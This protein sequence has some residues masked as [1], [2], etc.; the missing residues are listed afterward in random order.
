MLVV[1]NGTIFSSTKSGRVLMNMSCRRQ[2]PC[3]SL[4]CE[5]VTQS[6]YPIIIKSLLIKVC[7]IIRSLFFAAPF[8]TLNFPAG[9][10][11][12]EKTINLD[13]S[14]ASIDDKKEA[15]YVI[16]TV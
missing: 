5:T 16:T 8:A 3:N 6:A 9:S 15:L 1:V 10:G 13:F 11:N 12:R 2:S 7:E 4:L 14:T